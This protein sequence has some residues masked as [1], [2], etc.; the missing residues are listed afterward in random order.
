MKRIQKP[1]PKQRTRDKP[2]LL[3]KNLGRSVN[4]MIGEPFHSYNFEIYRIFFTLFA[5][6]GISLAGNNFL[7]EVQAQIFRNELFA[8]H[9]VLNEHQQEPIL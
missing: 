9:L 5:R 3:L 2:L 4:Q 1:N 8:T 7:L 6:D